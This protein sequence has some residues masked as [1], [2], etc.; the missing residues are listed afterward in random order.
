MTLKVR[1][2]QSS[3]KLFVHNFGRSDAVMIYEKMLISNTCIRGLMP[4]LNVLV[5]GLNSFESAKTNFG[6]IEG[7]GISGIYPGHGF[8]FEY[9]GVAWKGRVIKND[10]ATFNF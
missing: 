2:L 7:Q 8:K 3:R 9:N 6:S 1:I 5:T 10:L 4:N